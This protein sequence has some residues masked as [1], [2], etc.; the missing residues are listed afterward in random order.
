MPAY[1]DLGDTDVILHNNETVL[2]I[3]TKRTAF[4]LDSKSAYYESLQTDSKAIKQLNDSE[5]YFNSDNPIFN[6]KNRNVVKWV[7]STS[8]EGTN[9][10]IDSC[11]KISYFDIINTLSINNSFNSLEEFITFFENDR[12]FLWK[13]KECNLSSNIDEPKAYHLY[14]SSFNSNKYNKYKSIYSNA[15]KLNENRENKN[16]SHKQQIDL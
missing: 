8:F 1:Q 6:L 15:L 5:K 9:N 3:Q 10:V 12:L 7:V 11:R 13:L 14:Y 2:L 4:R 16:G